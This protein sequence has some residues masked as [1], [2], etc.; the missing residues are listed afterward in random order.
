MGSQVPRQACPKPYCESICATTM[1]LDM[2]PSFHITPDIFFRSVSSMLEAA[3]ATREVAAEDL[4][5][6]VAFFKPIAYAQVALA[7]Q[8]LS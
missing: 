8:D 6:L 2:K 3:L 4:S 7:R 5:N 1:T